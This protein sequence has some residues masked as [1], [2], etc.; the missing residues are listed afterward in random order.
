MQYVNN[1][2]DSQTAIIELARGKVNAINDDIVKE[3]RQILQQ[4]EHE[5]GIKAVIL[6]GRGSFFSFG[7]DI[8]HFMNY[9]KDA[10][11]N[12]LLDFTALYRYM[13]LYPKPIIAAINGH[14]IAGGCMLVT[15]CDY[16]IM[17][18]GK[19]KISLNEITFGASLFSGSVEILKHCTGQRN[20]EVVAGTGKMFT[21]EEA[22][23]LGLVDEVV[24]LEN[25]LSRADEI[26]IEYG[27]RTGPAYR[28]IK[29]L[30]RGPLTA[31]MEADDAQSIDD[32]IEIWYS[33]SM[34]KRLEQIKIHS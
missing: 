24:T 8:P 16:R 21:A 29:K 31:T 2:S 23:E 27:G 11:K 33:D 26:A 17:V 12:Y 14:A 1:I 10:F 5:D 30:V 13:F 22:K 20:A 25:L 4:I 6:T 9:S 19:A 34:R 28:G 3:L 18:T 15:T 7:F 32:F